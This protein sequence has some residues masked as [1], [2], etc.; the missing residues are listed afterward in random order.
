[1]NVFLAGGSGAIGVPIVRALVARFDQ[2]AAEQL[3]VLYGGSCK[4][5][6]AGELLALPDVDG[7]LVGG[8]SLD[9]SDFA[10]IVEAARTSEEP[11]LLVGAALFAASDRAALMR[12]AGALAAST[13]DR[14]LVAIAVA[15]LR[16]ER[17]LVLGIVVVPGVRRRVPDAPGE[18]RREAIRV[19]DPTHRSGEQRDGGGVGL[20]GHFSP[21]EASPSITRRCSTTNMIRTGAIAIRLAAISTG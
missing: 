19:R 15:H 4:P 17:E 20:P 5:S 2:G 16:G 12:R 14:Q 11:M 18:G 10:A 21:D 6:N 7:A 9:P 1:M 8:A 3:R 13:R